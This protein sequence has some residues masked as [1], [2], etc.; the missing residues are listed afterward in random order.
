ME[1][2]ED[3]FSRKIRFKEFIQM[4]P[5]WF[6]DTLFI[7]SIVCSIWYLI[8]SHNSS[9]TISEIIILSIVLPIT[10]TVLITFLFSHCKKW[11]TNSEWA[12]CEVVIYRDIIEALTKILVAFHRDFKN[13]LEPPR[14][15]GFYDL[16]M[17]KNSISNLRVFINSKAHFNTQN[18]QILGISNLIKTLSV[19]YTS[20][21]SNNCTNSSVKLYYM[22]IMTHLI[23][24]DEAISQLEN[25][26]LTGEA[27]I[28]VYRQLWNYTESLP[29]LYKIIYPIVEKGM[30]LEAMKYTF[31]YY[32]Q[33]MFGNIPNINEEEKVNIKKK[34]LERAW[35]TRN[36]E[37]KL[38]WQR[39]AYFWAFNAAIAIACYNI[40]ENIDRYIFIMSVLLILGT[41][42]SAAWFLSNIA[43]K[44]WQEN[45]ENHIRL[46]ETNI[47]GKLYATTVCDYEHAAKPS[48]SRI[49]FKI[50]AMVFF[51]WIVLLCAFCYHIGVNYSIISAIIIG[52]VAIAML[53]ILFFN[54]IDTWKKFIN[55]FQLLFKNKKYDSLYMY[56]HKI[57]DVDIYDKH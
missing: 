9:D 2:W 55:I 35:D 48:V 33:E 23:K 4:W 29:F 21:I 50:S 45:W 13:P 11:N 41:I 16:N 17:L 14:L 24:L 44:H 10:I 15:R 19:Q 34:A 38:Y 20:I 32:E 25:L 57:E 27:N 37:I 54:E 30:N 22:I 31:N 53:I 56:T 46:L 18:Y 36:F 5:Y 42:C 51:A 43:S 7:L 49:N 26:Q 28:D 12:E 39:A 52:I 47:E 1:W 6:I 40:L 8:K 3:P